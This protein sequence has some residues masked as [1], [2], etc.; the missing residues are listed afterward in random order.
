MKEARVLRERKKVNYK[1][2]LEESRAGR[3]AA[4]RLDERRTV[5]SIPPA[6]ERDKENRKR[7]ER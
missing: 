7:R 4:E 5:R 2:D 3:K 6:E 1:E